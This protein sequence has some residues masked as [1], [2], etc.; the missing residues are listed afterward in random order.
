MRFSFFYI[1]VSLSVASSS[2]FDAERQQLVD[3]IV[4]DLFMATHRIPGASV[5]VVRNGTVLMSKG[6]GMRNISAGL[7]SDGNTLFSIGSIS[8]VCS[9]PYLHE[10][11]E[12]LICNKI[13]RAL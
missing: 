4:E 5:S 9:V 8:K 1:I 13:T 12:R 6:Y 2:A 3:Y 10:L 7:P 11:I